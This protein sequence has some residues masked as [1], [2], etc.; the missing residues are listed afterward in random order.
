MKKKAI[1]ESLKLIRKQKE[2]IVEFLKI[3]NMYVYKQI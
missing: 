3:G 1:E 2:G